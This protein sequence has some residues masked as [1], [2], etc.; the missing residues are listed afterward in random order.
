MHKLTFKNNKDRTLSKMLLWANCHK[1]RKP[2]TKTTT[3]EYGL[4][5]VKDEGIYLMSPTDEKFVDS[6][7]V[8][9]TVVYARGYKP[10]KK[11]QDYL[12]DKT[13][14]VSGDDFAEF[15]PLTTDQVARVVRGGDIVININETQLA[16]AA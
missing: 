7:G 16:V 4:W 9:N 12:W 10:T 6:K 1:R 2:Y 8:I 14:A 5:L 13:H 3:E 11:N 15:I